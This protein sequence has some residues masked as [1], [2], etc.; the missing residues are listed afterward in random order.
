[1]M[2]PRIDLRESRDALLSLSPSQLCRARHG[3]TKAND[4]ELHAGRPN[5]NYKLAFTMA[6]LLIPLGSVKVLAQQAQ[7]WPP[8]D[9]YNG[10]GN[11]QYQGDPQSGD[12]QPQYSQ[13]PQYA[14]PQYQ[15]QPYQA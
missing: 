14:Q 10:Q 1:M 5:A 8:D 3:G 15:Q 9:S 4:F 7:G 11:G 6:L 12:S 2:E 13:Q